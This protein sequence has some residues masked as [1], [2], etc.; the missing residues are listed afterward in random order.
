MYFE[1]LGKQIPLYGI[2]FYIGIFAAG[3]VA[4]LICECKRLS[5]FDTVASGVY[6]MI[7]AIIGA[8]LLFILVSWRDI[9]AYKVEYELSLSDTLMS[10][11]KG[12]FVFYGGLIG[13]ALGLA[14]YVLQ[15]KMKLSDFAD[16]YAVVLPLGHAFGRIGCFFGGCCYGVPHDGAFSYTYTATAG[17]TPLGVP[18]LPVQLIEAIALFILFAILLGIFLGHTQ[19]TY[20]CVK[21][22]A[23]SYSVIRFIL[24][25]FRGDKERGGFLYLSTSQWISLVIF[26]L[27]ITKIIYDRQ[28]ADQTRSE[29]TAPNR[30]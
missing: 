20:L 26:V 8:K 6:A 19:H 11:I 4:L 24:E 16:I 1:F 5:K 7:G 2:F 22:Y 18:L 10:V 15:F 17:T 29:C 3:G 23:L 13:G 9:I 28:K 25:F 14:V 30:Q 27:V 21:I 12:G